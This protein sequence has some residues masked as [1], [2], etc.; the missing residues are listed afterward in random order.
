MSILI[1]GSD[2]LLGSELLRKLSLLG[3][4]P[5]TS[6][7]I[8]ELDITSPESIESFLSS[9]CVTPTTLINCAA[10]TDVNAAELE[11]N[12]ENVFAINALALKNLSEA[13]LSHGIHLIHISTDF[14]FD[15]ETDTPY[16]EFDQRNA[17]N[18]YG[19]SK[20]MGECAIQEAM[21]KDKN[22]SIFRLQW[23]YGNHS[24]TFFS[25][26]KK[27]ASQGKDLS[28]FEDE[29]GSPCSVSFVSDVLIDY[30]IKRGDLK[31]EI[32]HLTHNNSCSRYECGKFFIETLG[33][34]VDVNPSIGADKGVRRPMYG[35][36]SNTKL[37]K[38]LDRNLG[39]WEE[40]ILAYIYTYE[41]GGS[42]A[43]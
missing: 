23:L 8:D 15:G 18:Y 19:Q 35:V 42:S 4:I 2:G 13:C 22:F 25:K 21:H 31:G 41:K 39:T 24:K 26:I 17:V 34:P 1:T 38:F 29:F 43:S 20:L 33:I 9:L 14:V 16:Q 5:Y 32:Y 3:T 37:T 11:S 30:Y 7:S 40:D 36:L 12:K 28:I 6:S 27:I 10:Y